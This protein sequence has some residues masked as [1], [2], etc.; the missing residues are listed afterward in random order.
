MGIY[1]RKNLLRTNLY[2]KKIDM[3]KKNEW[4]DISTKTPPYEDG[5]I[6]YSCDILLTDGK[7][8]WVGFIDFE[9]GECFGNIGKQYGS[10]THWQSLPKLP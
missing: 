9:T 7:A 1:F 2:K 5:T 4:I 3:D 6:S 10:I 8:I